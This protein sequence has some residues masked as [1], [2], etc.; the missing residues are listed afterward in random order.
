MATITIS[1]LAGGA[2]TVNPLTGVE[3]SSITLGVGA[4]GV[5]IPADGTD[6][7]LLAKDGVTPYKGKWVNPYWLPIAGGRTEKKH[8]WNTVPPG[9]KRKNR[10]EGPAKFRQNLRKG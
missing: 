10:P 7:Q 1:P 6:G 3:I 4:P 9:K 5:G 2:I 8:L